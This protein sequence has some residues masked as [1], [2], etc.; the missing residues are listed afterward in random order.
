MKNLLAMLGFLLIMTSCSKSIDN[1]AGVDDSSS[2]SVALSTAQVP[3]AVMDA[4][5]AKY[6]NAGGEI[7]WQREDGNTYKVKFWLGAQR[8]QAIFSAA[9]GFISEKQLK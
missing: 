5:K 6:P 2:R 1:P 4:F 8:W 9:G 7:E 3:A